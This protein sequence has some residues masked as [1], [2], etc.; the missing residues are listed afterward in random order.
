MSNIIDALK[1]RYATKQFDTEKKLSAEQMNTLKEALRLA[2]SSFGLQ[3][4]H[5]MVVENVELRAKLRAVGYDQPQITEASH[6][7]VIASEKNV[8]AALVDKYMKNVAMVK[9]VPVEGLIGF[10]DMLNGAIQMKGE[11][12][13]E[14]WAARQ[15]Y[16]AVGILVAAAALEGIDAAPMEGFDPQAFDEIL[17]LS[18]KGLTSRVV[19]ALGSRKET[20]PAS[21]AKKVRYSEAEVFTTV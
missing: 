13:A 3:P 19:I 20:D 4:W 6:C 1:W 15:A 5:F 8:D 11:K 16:I 10:R 2:P 9:D 7:I 17:G 12:G 21:R 18:E 14:E